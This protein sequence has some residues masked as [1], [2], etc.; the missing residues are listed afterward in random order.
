MDGA[1]CECAS[2]QVQGGTT[3]LESLNDTTGLC[4]VL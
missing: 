1:D 2:G 4:V 3:M